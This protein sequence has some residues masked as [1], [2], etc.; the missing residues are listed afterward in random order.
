MSI[1]RTP[2]ISTPPPLHKDADVD[3]RRWYSRMRE[4]FTGVVSELSELRRC[5]R[6]AAHRVS[7]QQETPSASEDVTLFYTDR[8]ITIREVAAAILGTT[9]SVTYSIRYDPDRSATGTVA[10][11]ET[12]TAD[13]VVTEVEVEVPAASW[14]WL[15][16]SAASG[17]I[18]D[19]GVTIRYTED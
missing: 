4:W 3:L 10:H 13:G 17:T 18:A 5:C 7:Y 15:E 14:V 11:S 2:Y 16:T 1:N 12:L 8:D 19:F 9:P 6:E